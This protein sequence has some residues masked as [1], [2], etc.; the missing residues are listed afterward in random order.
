MLASLP[1]NS[2]WLTFRSEA[3]PAWFRLGGDCL[4]FMP[5]AFRP[6]KGVV[7]GA[8]C[9]FIVGLCQHG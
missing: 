3:V 2:Q 1:S 6:V 8:D 7:S 9:L 5:S 4:H